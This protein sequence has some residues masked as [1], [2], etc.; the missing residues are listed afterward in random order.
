MVVSL[1]A[2]ATA[3]ALADERDSVELQQA[4]SAVAAI[5]GLL[6]ES[7]GI[8]L[9]DADSDAFT[10]DDVS[11][12]IDAADPIEVHAAGAPGIEMEL[13][14]G[15]ATDEAVQ[16]TDGTVAY[17]DSAPQTS[18]VVQALD[19]GAARAMTILEGPAAPSSFDYAFS[20]ADGGQVTLETDE[21]GG[22]HINDSTGTQIGYVDP[23]WAVDAHGQPVATNYEIAGDTLTQTVDHAADAAYPIVADPRVT[24]GKRLYTAFSKSEVD[25]VL[26]LDRRYGSTAQGLATAICALLPGGALA[27]VPCTAVLTEAA[28]RV[29]NTFKDA[30][31]YNQCVQ[32]GI[33]YN[34]ALWLGVSAHRYNC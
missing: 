24:L 19:G 7:Q 18:I 3:P 22:I 8:D 10:T 2:T 25:R 23:A 21:V 30:D 32:I 11:L 4:T 20:T 17:T 13:P 26:A 9:V 29:R 31:R 6:D 14:A 5:P 28:T 34:W 16:V 1:L 15:S 27:K 33:P 12:P